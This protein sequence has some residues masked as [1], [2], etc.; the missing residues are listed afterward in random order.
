MVAL[1]TCGV[2][3]L[4]FDLAVGRIGGI[5][6][7]IVALLGYLVLWGGIPLRAHPPGPRQGA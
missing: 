2:V 7:S 5:V 3:F 1:T 6:A 4:T